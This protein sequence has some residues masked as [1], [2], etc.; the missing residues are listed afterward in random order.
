MNKAEQINNIVCDPISKE[1]LRR[2]DNAYIGKSNSYDIVN[3]IPVF[4]PP[5]SDKDQA[6]LNFEKGQK[7]GFSWAAK[8]WYNL[9][10]N[11]L[12]QDLDN[13][14]TKV[15]L[16][17]GSGSP[18]ESKFYEDRKFLAINFDINAKYLGVDVIGDAHSLPFKDNSIDIITSFEVFE[19]LKNPFVAAKEIFRVVKPGGCLIGSVAFL[20][21]YHSSFFHMTHMGVIELLSQSGLSVV[22]VYGGQNVFSRL[23]GHI[24]VVGNLKISELIF[25]WIG[26]SVFYFRRVAWKLKKGKKPTAKGYTSA[27]GLDLS[28]DDYEKLLFAPTVIFKAIKK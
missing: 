21:Q 19:H 28:F 24:V 5:G 26:L 20:K 1:D 22:K 3:N 27:R 14:E 11:E 25:G 2:T 7:Q 17:I 23:I 8:H 6:I 16:N 12:F 13:S 9:K 10:I 15:L 4:L 18:S